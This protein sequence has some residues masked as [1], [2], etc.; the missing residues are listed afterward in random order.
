MVMRIGIQFHKL[1]R[2]LSTVSAI[3]SLTLVVIA[4]FLRGETSQLAAYG[5]AVLA[6][7]TVAFIELSKM[8]Q[9]RVRMR[10][11]RYETQKIIKLFNQVI[12]LNT[13]LCND[14]RKSRSH[15][16]L[17]EW[18][19]MTEKQFVKIHDSLEDRAE[20]L[21]SILRQWL[22]WMTNFADSILLD[23]LVYALLKEARFLNRELLS[24]PLTRIEN[25]YLQDDIKDSASE[26][27]F[28]SLY[29]GYFHENK[30]T[31]VELAELIYSP[32][33]IE[34][35]ALLIRE[36][37]TA[38]SA[39]QEAIS[40]AEKLE[41]SENFLDKMNQVISLMKQAIRDRGIDLEEYHSI[42]YENMTQTMAREVFLFLKQES[43]DPKLLRE[44][45]E[46]LKKEE[47]ISV[48]PLS[49]Y[50]SPALI[51]SKKLIG[52]E[53]L[54]K[55][56][57]EVPTLGPKFAMVI[58]LEMRSSQVIQHEISSS[59]QISKFFETFQRIL[60]IK[61]TAE[62]LALIL[63]EPI[64]EL[65][66]RTGMVWLLDQELNTLEKRILQKK[67][68]D[69]QASLQEKGFVVQDAFSYSNISIKILSAIFKE[70][71]QFSEGK[72]LELAQSLV[73]QASFWKGICQDYSNSH[74]I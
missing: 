6:A 64:A 32:E 70:T 24:I 3:L 33:D 1:S 63:K 55:L 5:A 66:R 68:P 13:H 17:I 30:Q 7:L 58:P 34:E 41:K 47:E 42:F 45:L 46:Q 57:E 10:A 9:D 20:A 37:R 18:L 59:T 12:S 72:S 56:F 54:I 39:R 27:R 69:I 14:L 19:Q 50:H 44:K 71:V 25:T 22:G 23:F 51:I 43:G 35:T 16:E 36:G 67:E 49:S 28:L 62:T 31:V 38:F 74:P 40:L 15:T 48:V 60:D 8:Y 2:L 65:I 53:G 73:E 21:L 11:A 52:S 29:R 61:E 26:I 4:F